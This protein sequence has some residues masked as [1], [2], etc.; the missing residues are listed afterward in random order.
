M[1]HPTGPPEMQRVVTHL[2]VMFY[3]TPWDPEIRDAL[4]NRVVFVCL[5]CEQ[6]SRCGFSGATMVEKDKTGLV[7]HQVF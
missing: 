5:G 1:L 3:T 4:E 6:T 2:S 7:V